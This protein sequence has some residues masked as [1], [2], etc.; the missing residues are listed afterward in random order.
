MLAAIGIDAHLASLPHAAAIVGA[1]RRSA[2]D[3]T[4]LPTDRRAEVLDDDHHAP[5]HATDPTPRTPADPTHRRATRAAQHFV[6][7]LARGVVSA[8]AARTG[9]ERVLVA[10]DDRPAGYHGYRLGGDAFFYHW[11]ANA[12]AKGTW[13]VDPGRWAID[14]I[15]RPSAG[16]PP[17]Y[18]S[19]LAL[20]SSLGLDG[21]TAHRLASSMLGVAAIVVVGLLARRIAGDGRR[22]VAAAMHRGVSVDLD[23]RRHAAVGDDGDLH[24]RGRAKR[25]V[26][27]LAVAD[28][29]ATR[30]CSGSR[31][32]RRR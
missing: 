26:R 12:L 9:D 4:P 6:A 18:S 10:A 28:D 31:S 20:W 16:H 14:G 29:A 17:L 19:Y 21:V 25:R 8:R 3:A 27:V 32:G 23:Q 1:A 24:D 5:T 7:W 30:C 13:F 15:E 11:Q 2:P 22:L